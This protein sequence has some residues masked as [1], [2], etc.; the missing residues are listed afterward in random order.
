ME[1]K[2]VIT[3]VGWEPMRTLHREFVEA[4][5][6]LGLQASEITYKNFCR[7]FAPR[8]VDMGV[9]RRVLGVR[10]PLI[11]DASRFDQAAF[12]LVTMASEE[13]IAQ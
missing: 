5:P 1:Q 2:L 3:Q 11:A 6:E 13:A 10:S 8:L 7:L 9:A 4:H 12:D